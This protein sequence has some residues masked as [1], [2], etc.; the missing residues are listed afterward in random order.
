MKPKISLVIPVYNV[1]NHLEKCLDSCVNQTLK[2]I[3]I[4]I[5]DD[6]SSDKSTQI[7]KRYEKND[8]RIRYLRHNKN[9]GLFQARKTGTV[10]STGEYV[11]HLDSDDWL[12][13][14]TCETIYTALKDNKA[15]VCHIGTMLWEHGKPF[16]SKDPYWN[17]YDEVLSQK[18]LLKKLLLD[19]IAHGAVTLIAKR[20][21]SLSVYNEIKNIPRLISLED[22]IYS[23]VLTLKIKTCVCIPKRFYNYHIGI[24]TGT[25]GK[26]GAEK[27]VS[28]FSDAYNAFS[29]ITSIALS[30]NNDEALKNI[31]IKKRRHYKEHR[32]YDWSFLDP[33]NKKRAI[34]SLQQKGLLEEW[35]KVLFELGK[36]EE[37]TYLTNLFFD[38][39]IKKKSE[40][41]R[42][43]F[44]INRLNNGGRERVVQLLAN[45]L[46]R[47]GW[48]VFIFTL[49]NKD[50][51]DYPLDEGV[52]RI[53]LPQDPALLLDFFAEKLEF[54]SIRLVASH[55][56]LDTREALLFCFLRIRGT[57]ICFSDH[58]GLWEKI[59]KYNDNLNVKN[60][61]NIGETLNGITCLTKVDTSFW[62]RMGQQ[63]VYMPN[64]IE[65]PK[66]EQTLGK[67]H[68]EKIVWVGR[69]EKENKRTEHAINAFAV[70]KKL[71][72]SAKL[73]IVGSEEGEKLG[74]YYKELVTLCKELECDKDVEFLG[75]SKNVAKHFQESSVHWL[76]S[77][78]EGFP[79]VWIEAKSFSVPTVLYELPAVEL[80]GKGSIIVPQGDYRALANV[81]AELLSNKNKLKALSYEAREDLLI[82]FQ[83]EV[84]LD[85][86]EKFYYEILSK[87]DSEFF[88]ESLHIKQ[89][90]QEKYFKEYIL[91]VIEVCDVNQS[92]VE[93]KE[94]EITNLNLL[95]EE[96]NNYIE[97]VNTS[98]FWKLRNIWH[99]PTVS[100]MY[101][102]DGK[103][104]DLL[105]ND[106]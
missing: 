39:T 79:M 30:Y 56:W 31:E 38:V 11:Q 8:S 75:Y 36:Y 53:V 65:L 105:L 70:L 80:N 21:I 48:H 84:I 57:K 98:K 73:M 3:E 20:S 32:F 49:E 95:L 93:K 92:V 16:I 81:T 17:V 50:K 22:L 26:E 19:Q 77:A 18:K 2:E 72:P 68:Y 13:K 9:R 7:A 45:G 61:L 83:P 4:I 104:P 24:G 12:E 43:A 1:E 47:R 67:K 35:I 82:R 87:D 91:K 40:E 100:G 10:K 58:N 96:K 41:K 64:P 33:E 103:G 14:N 101:R 6:A 62:R 23:F 51:K 44:Y 106:E 66:K 74:P 42:I 85:R 5:V 59:F 15:D 89:N 52:M 34:K 27:F 94:L 76:T 60:I 78:Y 55:N 99:K 25:R 102:K 37:F 28:V 54:F 29:T 90:V 63:V 88:A 86:W 46:S 69:L 97:F 71:R